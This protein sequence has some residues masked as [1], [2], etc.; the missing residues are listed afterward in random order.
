MKQYNEKFSISAIKAENLHC[1]LNVQASRLANIL[2]HREQRHYL[3][4]QSTEFS[5]EVRAKM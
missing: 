3:A 4:I 1:T 2:C 5:C